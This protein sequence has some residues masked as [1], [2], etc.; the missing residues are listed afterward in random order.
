MN[1]RILF[2]IIGAA[3]LLATIPVSI[4]MTLEVIHNIKMSTDYQITNLSEGEPPS[5]P[6]YVF[7]DHIIEIEE[8]LGDVFYENAWQNKIGLGD[9]MVSIDTLEIERLKDHPIRIEED[10]LNR[11]YGE[12]SYLNIEDRKQADSYLIVLVKNS[13]E[14]ITTNE[15]GDMLGFLPEEEL[16]YTV[17]KLDQSGTIASES[18]VFNERNAFQTELLNHSGVAPYA[19]GYHTDLLEAYPSLFFP[20]LYPFITFIIGISLIIFFFPRR[21][22]K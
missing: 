15:N 12:V 17:H 18:F 8:N 21:I 16:T 13:R 14:I 2:F 1:R 7:N 22:K 19:I 20:V 3:L 6:L 9:I 11:Y 4:P 5:D 10:G